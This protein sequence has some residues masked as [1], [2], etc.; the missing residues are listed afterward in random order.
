TDM[1]V[2]ASEDSFEPVRVAAFEGLG[3]IMKVISEKSMNPYLEGLDDIRKGKIKEF[4][5]KAEVKVKVSAVKKPPVA[6]ATSSKPTKSAKPVAKKEVVRHILDWF[7]QSVLI[8]LLTHQLILT[9]C[10]KICFEGRRN[11]K[12]TSEK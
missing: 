7:I 4:Y 2:K 6:A 1:L 5:E 10:G 9:L 12:D 3:T 11:Q 8:L